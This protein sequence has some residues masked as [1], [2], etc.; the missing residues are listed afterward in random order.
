MSTKV[1]LKICV[2]TLMFVPLKNHLRFLIVKIKQSISRYNY[3]N[4]GVDPIKKCHAWNCNTSWWCKKI[5]E[6]ANNEDYNV[7]KRVTIY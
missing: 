6:Y 2:L 5:H 7:I 4:V 3:G 1:K